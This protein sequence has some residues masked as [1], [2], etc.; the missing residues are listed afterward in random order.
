MKEHSIKNTIIT[1]LALFLG[2]LLGIAVT[3]QLMR[4]SQNVES[5]HSGESD[6]EHREHNDHAESSANHDEHG[7]EEGGHIE[8]TDAEISELSIKTAK[9]GQGKLH[10]KVKLPGEIRLHPDK[11]A[12]IVP[13][14]GGIVKKVNTNLGDHVKEGEVMA[15]LES[16]EL[17]DA[18]SAYLS[19]LQQLELTKAAYDREKK[20]WEKK[21]SSEQDYLDARQAYAEAKINLNN[22]EQQL[23]ALGF[24]EEY[25]EKLPILPD[26]SYTQYEITAPFDGTVINKHITR[27][28]LVDT[29]SDIFEVANLDTVWAILTVYQKNLADVQKGQNVTIHADKISA[30]FRGVVD[31]L[32]PIVEESTRTAS[33][34]VVLDNSSGKWRPGLFVVGEIKTA[35]TELDLVIPKT[36][37]QNIGEEKVVFIKAEHGFK[38][39]HI[40]TGRSSETHVEVVSGLD[41]GQTIAVRNTFTLKAEL[42]K[43]SFGGHNH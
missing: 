22:A 31:Y 4:H 3:F 23:Y 39:S 29:S 17:A 30:E 16:R 13:R 19:G 18:K 8:L 26:A 14:V 32:S 1:V 5:T 6:I 27:G 42:N 34:R 35:D 43:G 12:H 15:V 24:D 20:L 11:L 9:A 2:L 37:V 38:P 21:V 41:L 10:R 40:Q 25:M 33:A 7:E 36:A 28:E